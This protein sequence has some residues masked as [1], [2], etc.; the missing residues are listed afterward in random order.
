MHNVRAAAAQF[1]TFNWSFPPTIFAQ[2][3]KTVDLRLK[4]SGSDM[5]CC[6]NQPWSGQMF[7]VIIISIILYIVITRV[8]QVCSTA[9]QSVYLCF[10]IDI[11]PNID[12][13]LKCSWNNHGGPVLFILQFC[14]LAMGHHAMA[15]VHSTII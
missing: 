8:K 3:K 1:L 6:N 11:R 10:N 4:R 15:I 5:W 12:I 9:T 2:G 13:Y 7:A 14:K